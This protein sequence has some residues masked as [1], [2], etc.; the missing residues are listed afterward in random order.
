[1]FIDNQAI[2][3]YNRGIK[4]KEF[5]YGRKNLHKRKTSLL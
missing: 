4:Y 5:H 3:Y 1:M 2:I